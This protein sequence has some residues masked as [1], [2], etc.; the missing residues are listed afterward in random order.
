MPTTVD[1]RKQAEQQISEIYLTNRSTNFR[2][3]PKSSDLD[4][5]INTLYTIPEKSTR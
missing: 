4:R 3:L 2:G 1:A 5:I